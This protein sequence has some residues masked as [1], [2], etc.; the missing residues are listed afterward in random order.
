MA[1]PVHDFRNIVLWN[2][3]P[4]SSAQAKGKGEGVNGF[5]SAE[6]RLCIKQF[7][8]LLLVKCFDPC[9]LRETENP[10][11]PLI[12]LLMKWSSVHLSI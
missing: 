3:S 5:E 7:T 9:Y 12:V 4:L 10:L 1:P 11:L 6:M 2:E 8:S